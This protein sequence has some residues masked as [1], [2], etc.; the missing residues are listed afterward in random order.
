MPRIW[1][2]GFLAI[3]AL[4]V[5]I[6]VSMRSALPLT[7]SLR[8]STGTVDLAF[9]HRQPLA[10]HVKMST[11][12]GQSLV[13]I[14]HEG[15]EEVLISV[16]S[17]WRRSEVKNAPLTSVVSEAPALGFTRWHFPPK[18]SVVFYTR[19]APTSLMIHNPTKVPLKVQAIRVHLDTNEVEQEIVL[20]K[21]ESVPIW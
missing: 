9:E 2:H 14:S 12:K 5:L 20:V 15:E 17:T 4:A 11:L 1:L 10:A 19:D 21:D 6:A 3:G 16:P 18:T 8:M 7:A 13:E